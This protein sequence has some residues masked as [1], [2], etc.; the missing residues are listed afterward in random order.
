VANQHQE[1]EEWQSKSIGQ[2]PEY[3]HENAFDKMMDSLN[4]LPPDPRIQ[5]ECR[6][7]IIHAIITVALYAFWGL[8]SSA[9]LFNI[10]LLNSQGWL[11]RTLVGI[12]LAGVMPVGLYIYRVK[13]RGE[14]F[15]WVTGFQFFIWGGIPVIFMGSILQWLLL[16]CGLQQ[17]C[18][19]AIDNWHWSFP[20]EIFGGY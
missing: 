6:Y 20:K 16:S 10:A 17:I 9:M 14:Y 15:S 13:R 7:E 4:R 8:F 12:L 1:S 5:R 18:G 2:S 19:L 3:S 11:V